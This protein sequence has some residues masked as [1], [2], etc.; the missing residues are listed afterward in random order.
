MRAHARE[1]RSLL[2]ARACVYASVCVCALTYSNTYTRVPR[3]NKLQG[4]TVRD[5]RN[6]EVVAHRYWL[7]IGPPSSNYSRGKTRMPLFL[8][9]ITPTY[10]FIFIPSIFILPDLIPRLCLDP[11]LRVLLSLPFFNVLTFGNREFELPFPSTFP[12]STL[13]LRLSSFSSSFHS[14]EPSV[15]YD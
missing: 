1:Y 3:V 14:H 5:E 12:P 6:E 15:S 11:V 10:R 8:P 7:D 9:R 4:T 13:F 2:R